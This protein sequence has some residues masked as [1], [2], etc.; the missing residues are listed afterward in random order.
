MLKVTRKAMPTPSWASSPPEVS[1]LPTHSAARSRPAA[2]WLSSKS[3]C[4]P[5]SRQ[6][7]WKRSSRR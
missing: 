7:P 1:F 2:T 6:T 4:A 5:R 3:G